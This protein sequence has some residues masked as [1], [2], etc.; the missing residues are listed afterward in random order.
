MSQERRQPEGPVRGI[1]PLRGPRPIFAGALALALIAVGGGLLVHE[2]N[3]PSSD[4]SKGKDP[5]PTPHAVSADS[6]ENSFNS[7]PQLTPTPQP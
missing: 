6:F 2:S 3:V 4:K 7:E 5:T 1:N